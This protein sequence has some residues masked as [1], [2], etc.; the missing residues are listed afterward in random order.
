M[1]SMH[2]LKE[3]AHALEPVMRIGKSG[4][5]ESVIAELLKQLKKKKL[6]KV[7][8][9]KSFRE[10]NERTQSAAELAARTGSVVIE[11]IGNAVVLWKE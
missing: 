9:L 3:Q 1:T 8:L 10:G 5:T 7:K 6:I 11:M 4:L 2:H